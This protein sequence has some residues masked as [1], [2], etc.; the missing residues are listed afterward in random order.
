M[1]GFLRRHRAAIASHTALVVAAGA[2]LAYAISADGYQSHRTEL[3]DGGIWVT[4]SDKGYF[5]RL[6]KPINRLDGAVPLEQDA[7]LDVHQDG[8]S[9]VGVNGR[10]G[11]LVPLDPATLRANDGASASLAPGGTVAMVGGTLAA[12]DPET[13][14]TWAVR[15]DEQTGAPLVA[16]LDQQAEPLAK[17]GAGAAMT[18]TRGGAVV[19]VSAGK[20][21][22]ATW[23]PDP[24]QP[25][26]QEP[27]T[28]ELPE[29]AGSPDAMTSVGEVAVTLDREGGTL[30]T[31]A[32]GAATVEPGALLQQPGPAADTVLVAHGAGLSEV[33][34]G[35]GRVSTLVGDVS[36]T[37]TAPVRLGPCVFAAWSGG[38]GT[39]ATAC[40]DEAPQVQSLGARGTASDLVFRV[41]RGDIVLNDADSGTVWEVD[42]DRPLKIDNWEAFT[43]TKKVE[44]EQPEDEQ[45]TTGDRRPPQAEPDDFGARAGRTSVLYPLDND[46]APEGRL[47]AIQGVD[48]P[49]IPGARVAISP[50]RQTLQLTLPQNARGQASFDYYIDD[51]RNLK[52]Q[53]TV[54]VAV[55]GGQENA[56]PRLRDNYEPRQWRMP[57]GGTLE[58]PVLPDWR[59][60]T[61]SD[62]L[63][64][65]SSRV[66]G[67]LQDVVTRTTTSGRLRVKAPAT[68]GEV[69]LEYAVSDGLSE[70]VRQVL[71]VTVQEKFEQTTYPAVAEPD[72]VSGEVG[73]PIIVR[74]LANDLP[75]SDP[76]TPNAQLELGGRIPDQAGA[77][78]RTDVNS[79]VVRV[80]AVKAGTYL[81]DYQTAYGNARLARGKIRVDVRP[82]PKNPQDPVASPDTL[83]LYGQSAATVDVLANDVDPAGGILVVQ[84]ARPDRE[85][86]V[87]VAVVEGRWLRISARQGVLNPSAQVVRYTISNGSV[88]GVSGE[89]LVTQRPVPE[90][91][92]PVTGPDRVVVRAGQVVA[93]PVLDNDFSPSGDRLDLAPD[94]ATERSGELEVVA[95][96]DYVGEAGTAYV[97]G[98]LVRYVAPVDLEERETFRVPYVAR[99]TT[100]ETAPGE[101]AVVVVPDD[102]P[103]TAPEPPALE[104][105]VVA[106]EPLRLK[107]PG[108]EVDP[109][110]DPVVVTG[111]AS[112]PRLGRLLEHGANYLQY[113]SYPGVSGT[114]EFTYTITDAR[115]AEATGVARV[116]V[117]PAG[118]PQAPV[119]VADEIT[120][121]PGAT[122]RVD[123]LANDEIGSAK[124]V[125]LDLVDPPRGVRLDSEIGPVLVD[126]PADP[127]AE[128]VEV[129]YS[130]DNGLQSSLATLRVETAEGFNNP[131]V[132]QDAFGAADAGDAVKVDLLAADEDRPAAYDPDGSV[133]D[134]RV[135]QVYAEEGTYELVG[136]TVTVTRGE[137]PRVVPFRVEDAQGG[138]A[139]AS[140]YVPPAAGGRPYLKA[141]SLIEVGSGASK[142]F[143]L[144]KYVANPGGGSLT[145][146]GSQQVWGS[147]RSAVSARGTSDT[148]V[149]LSARDDFRGPAAVMVEVVGGTGGEDGGSGSA[150]TVISIPVQVGDDR[151]EIDCTDTPIDVAASD[152]VV[153]DVPSVCTV[154]GPTLEPGQ[155]Y[156][157]GYSAAWS[158]EVPGV[159]LAADGGPLLNVSV[160]GGTRAGSVAELTVRAGD[161]DPDT[162]RVRVTRAPSPSLLSI[163]VPDMKPGASKEI[164]LA[165][166]LR[167]G[168]RD[169]RPTILSVRRVS[170]NSVNPSSSG[171]TLRLQAPRGAGGRTELQVEMS[172]VSS[173]DPGPER[174]VSGRISVEVQDVPTAPG[175]PFSNEIRDRS[176]DLSWAPSDPRGSRI[177]FYEV[178]LVD[179]SR[180]QRF[181]SNRGTFRV[182]DNGKRYA[183]KVRAHNK[184]GFSE[185]SGRSRSAVIDRQPGVVP[186]IRADEIGD[187]TLTLRWG[188]APT[189]A[190]D[191]QMYYISWRDGAQEVVG[192]KRSTQIPG[193]DN[194]QQYTFSVRARNATGTSEPRVSDPFQTIGTPASPKGL[195]MQDLQSGAGSTTVRLDWAGTLPE[196]PAPT[197]YSVRATVN[198]RGETLPGC[199]RITATTCRHEGVPYDGRVWT[200]TVQAHNERNTSP[201]ST[202]QTFAAV[203][204]P[205]PWGGWS[206]DATGQ[207][208]QVR[209]NYQVPPSRGAQSNVT[210]LVNGVP[211]R[212]ASQTGQQAQVVGLPNN[213][214]PHSVR[215]RVCNEQS[216]CS[217]SSV[218]DAQSY[219]PLNDQMVRARAE[220]A[221]SRVTWV[222]EGNNNG[223]PGKLLVR[224]LDVSQRG[225]PVLLGEQTVDLGGYGPGTFTY[226]MQPVELGWRSTTRVEVTLYDDAPGNRG[227]GNAAAEAGTGDPPAPVATLTKVPC[228]DGGNAN[229]PCSP[230]ETDPGDRCYS[231]SCGFVSFRVTGFLSAYGC[232]VVR[233]G[234]TSETIHSFQ[235]A[236]G[237]VAVTLP[238]YYWNG[239][240]SIDCTTAD[241]G[242]KKRQNASAVK[243]W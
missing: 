220:V 96:Q 91:N 65:E 73:K 191:I 14:S 41:N 25:D 131:P 29:A 149:E 95:R 135:T 186:W 15:Y 78:V 181:R 103:N 176:V 233:T 42:T 51:G 56:A 117:V 66:V 203:G 100:G 9:V 161:S 142:R 18:V 89:V 85:G 127:D 234:I 154:V 206:W 40:G 194:N 169:P 82:P 37:P 16:A 227:A 147:P 80:D 110:G 242:D 70:P 159:E 214:Q 88:S 189:R 187:G 55:R 104:G 164:D 137:A 201:A 243:G 228:N 46:A 71:N 105:R 183:F 157:L 36:G 171:S 152:A 195:T 192:T 13:G 199:R 111:I 185:W 21:R 58:L 44:K 156:A 124:R 48:Q 20:E 143:K 121:A 11:R 210:V 122:A 107:L 7:D 144:D 43:D 59:D 188:K 62:P 151:P 83:T 90:D 205:E 204:T 148:E 230:P 238:N 240:L 75:G 139:S 153:I 52:D 196:G 150:P 63:M 212:T 239:T 79:G 24:A 92:T 174:R 101:L 31:T 67:G 102:G 116:A 119:A 216:K 172:D 114:D 49:N 76:G 129:V 163:S 213:L 134:L 34:L 2:V 222:V 123:V 45:Q 50:D 145:L 19:V 221:G 26:L 173:D 1:R 8:A 162:I 81:L 224:T 17:V 74:P 202:P 182:P 160:D 126:A 112:A 184:V 4:K 133:D 54:T 193:L 237:D 22:V 217:E 10:A 5:G 215:L 136:N 23:Q 178:A 166:Y 115:G 57:A 218:Q 68:G 236:N 86:Q 35:S 190:S 168:V 146:T 12:V 140:L 138:A 232:S 167:A 27:T 155:E 231:S 60:P 219:G 109:D 61:D 158:Q 99:N 208:N 125:T 30:W 97:S 118:L 223:N 130:L 6:N 229:N 32:G 3:N 235:D 197:L 93:H 226:P 120:V 113:Q 128:T 198:G 64:L 33:D 69:Q 179:G 177:D 53:A 38:E 225:A 28:E 77:K 170:G 108:S 200:Y 175:A 207:D 165:R 180:S 209:V 94:S 39:L 72:V 98:R 106:G 241:Q 87:D 47:L 211:G 141:G 132:V 84:D